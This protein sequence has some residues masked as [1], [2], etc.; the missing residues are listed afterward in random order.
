LSGV[1]RSERQIVE[2]F[3]SA[4]RD[5]GL[6]VLE[7]FHALK[8]AARFGAELV[9]VVT[10][11]T[12]SAARLS[13]EHAPDLAPALA[14]AEVVEPE[15]FARLAPRPHPTGV[16]A[17]ARRPSPRAVLAEIGREP[18]V[19]LE[20]PRRPE[21][22]GAVIRVAAAAGAA[23]V[24][25]LG[26]VD[27]WHPAAVRG[28]AGLQFALPVASV[29]SLGDLLGADPSAPA[30]RPL[31]AFDPDGEPL[32]PGAI[33]PGALLA[34]GSERRGLSG[35]LLARAD[36]RLAI[37]MRKGVSSLNLATAVAVALYTWRLGTG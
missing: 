16:V 21:N 20:D 33:P 1:D 28:A 7:G 22:L 26:G 13:Q 29:A 15:V 17:I 18:V 2:R 34:F 10:R 35:A 32:V 30:G 3:Q 27:P 36:R 5:P 6:V 23:G 8:H 12:D 37:P 4:R 14:D 31:V 9:D 19:V 11:D 24:V 25:T